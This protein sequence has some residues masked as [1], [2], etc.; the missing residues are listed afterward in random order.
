MKR[1]VVVIVSLALSMLGLPSFA[2]S[3]LAQLPTSTPSIEFLNPSAY[4][5]A[6]DLGIV[7]SNKQT[8]RPSRG[9]T[10][11][12]LSAWIADAPLDAAVEFELLRGGLSLQTIDATRQVGADT[13]E[14]DWDISD[15]LPPGTYTLRATVASGSLAAAST[16]QE[17]TLNQLAERAEIDYPRYQATKAFPGDGQFGT[18]APLA[19]SADGSRPGPIG[20][21]DGKNSGESDGAGTSRVRAF[22]TTSSPGTVPEWT[23]CGT[24]AAPGDAFLSSAAN[25][26]VRCTLEGSY[27]QQSITAVALVANT[28]Q[29][30]YDPRLNGS[31]DAVRVLQPYAQV[32][33]DFSYIEGAVETVDEGVDGGYGCHTAIANL[34]DQFGREIAGANVDVEAIGPTDSLKFDLGLLPESGIKAPDEGSHTYEAGY[35]C[36]GDSDQ[37]EPGEQAE[38]QVVGGP[39]LKLVEADESGTDDTG[40]WGFSVRTPGGDVT[41]SKFTTYYSAWVDEADPGSETNDDGYTTSELCAGGAVGWGSFPANPETSMTLLP[42][43][44]PP[45]CPPTPSATATPDGCGTE[46]PPPAAETLTMKIRFVGQTA[47]FSGRLTSG[48]PTCEPART[49]ILKLRSGGRYV[50]QWSGTTDTEGRWNIRRTNVSNGKWKAVAPA[51]GTCGKVASRPIRIKG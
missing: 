32:P 26:G 15:M 46:E 5:P 33:T 29:D 16:D 44:P 31:G 49:I 1:T 11:Y 22:Y 39:D 2:P 21:I 14:A 30:E 3:S 41:E 4:A 25:N 6:G 47:V 7:V 18:F 34:K 45:L 12:R 24:E 43:Q 40:T 37:T 50:K 51:G 19:T 36:F 27:D 8:S 13:W 48:D 28:S 20:N 9:D 35:D 10:T 23:E 17:I 38:R 42:C